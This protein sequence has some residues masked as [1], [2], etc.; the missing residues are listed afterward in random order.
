[1]QNWLKLALYVVA[2]FA[3]IVS[4]K[5]CTAHLGVQ[6]YTISC[7]TASCTSFRANAQSTLKC[8]GTYGAFEYL[9]YHIS[10]SSITSIVDVA[11]YLLVI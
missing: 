5:M 6:G 10:S 8:C 2:S 1:M 11:I 9:Q 7:K 3:E 4:Q